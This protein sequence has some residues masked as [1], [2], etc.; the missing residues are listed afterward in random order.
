MKNPAAILKELGSAP[1]HERGLHTIAGRVIGGGTHAVTVETGLATI[2]SA[3][4]VK[5]NATTAVLGATIGDSTARV[6]T[7]TVAFTVADTGVYSYI[8]TG[9]LRGTITVPTT[10]AAT[11]VTYNPATGR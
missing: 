9:Y 7:K 5:E 8:I 6:G 4:V 11:T 2:V 1:E 3:I 10:A